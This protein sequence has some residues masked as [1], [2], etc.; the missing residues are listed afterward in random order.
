MQPHPLIQDGLISFV[1]FAGC[2]R[3]FMPN[4]FYLVLSWVCRGMLLT[5]DIRREI[6][7]GHSLLP[8]VDPAKHIY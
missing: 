5:N 6:A 2:G 4:I 7:V 1:H 3:I 8:C